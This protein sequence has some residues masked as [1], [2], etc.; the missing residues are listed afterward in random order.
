MV[1]ILLVIV[2]IGIM[3][4]KPLGVKKLYIMTGLLT[5]LEIIE[6]KWLHL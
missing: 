4:H 2:H 5:S 6:K 1:H 3:I